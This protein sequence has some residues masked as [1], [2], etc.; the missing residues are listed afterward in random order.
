MVA[1]KRDVLFY[2]LSLGE[3]P[4]MA[5]ASPLNWPEMNLAEVDA[6]LHRHREQMESLSGELASVGERAGIIRKQWIAALNEA[7]FTGTMATLYREPYLF[8]LQGWIP[9]DQETGFKAKLA[10]SGLPLHTVARGPLDGEEPP[11]LIRNNWFVRRI[12]PLQQLYGLPRLPSTW[13]LLPSSRPSWCCS[14]GSA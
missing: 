14:S 9:Q 11:I 13:I 7:A 12:Q 6:E 1:R 8:G 2:T 5:H 4:E 10:E 3:S